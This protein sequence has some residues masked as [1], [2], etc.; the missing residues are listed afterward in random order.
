LKYLR[1]FD[2]QSPV[3]AILKEYS[4]AYFAI[5]ILSIF[6]PILYLAGPIYTIQIMDR[7]FTSRN[8]ETLIALT[9]IALFAI[10]TS[11]FLDLI[12]Q[13]AMQRIGRLV[14]ERLGRIVFAARN[15][16]FKHGSNINTAN[17]IADVSIVSE[18]AS[19]RLISLLFDAILSPL[20]IIVLFFIHPVFGLLGLFLLIISDGLS[21]LNLWLVKADNK[22]FQ[23]STIQANEFGNAVIRSA[24]TIRA[25]GMVPQLTERWYAMQR[26]A[27]D[28]QAS[29][30]AKSDMVA[31]VARF[32]RQAQIVIIYAVGATLYL[33]NLISPSVL[34]AVMMITMRALGPIDAVI[35][36]WSSYANVFAAYQRLDSLILAVADTARKISLPPPSG[37]ITVENLIATG[38]GS[39]RIIV[40]DVSFVLR[41]GRVLGV[42]GASGAGKSSLAR[43]LAGVWQPRRGSITIGA[44]ELSHWDQDKLGVHL[45]Y[46]PQEVELLPGTL[47]ENIARFNPVGGDNSKKLLQAAENAGIGDLIKGLPE[48]Y[49]TRV[50]PGFHVF[51]G[52]QRQRIALARALYGDPRLVVLDEPNSNLDAAGEQALVSAIEQLRR[53]NATV[54][55]VTHKLSLLNCCDDVLVMHAGA[56]QAFGLKEQIVNRIPRLGSAAPALRAIEGGSEAR[57]P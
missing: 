19:G 53:R 40:N 56:V 11:S 23:A 28:W 37:D 13:K 6:S 48:G 41:E 39:D 52:G 2:D 32:L 8:A 27:V 3:M 30:A 31:A 21:L 29:I 38:P 20:F 5:F 17:A 44:H 7:V 46:M 50:G 25:M 57:R 9:V 35:A 18:F 34:I 12:R 47:A 4:H 51:S 49:N 14:N 22:R 15:R 43:L 26:T 54:I 33:L 24:E 45:G 42:V 1:K 36:S 55:V 16:E 10:L